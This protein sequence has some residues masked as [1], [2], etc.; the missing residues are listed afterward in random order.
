MIILRAIVFI[1][2]LSVT[3]RVVNNSNSKEVENELCD[4]PLPSNTV[5]V[6][7]V[8]KS[9]KLV[10]NGNGMQ[11]LGAISIKSDLSMEELDDYY[12]QYRYDDWSYLIES[13]EGTDI[14]IIEHGNLDFSSD[15]GNYIVYTWG[16]G[17]QFFELWDI[18][19]N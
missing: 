6:D 14:D 2:I 8:S 13:Q 17:N 19:G 16:E 1:V 5:V 15:E 11:Y 9:A 18:R 12:S 4:T 10:G 3:S 7:S